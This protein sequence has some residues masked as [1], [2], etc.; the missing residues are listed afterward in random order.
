[1]KS[2]NCKKYCNGLLCKYCTPFIKKENPINGIRCNFIGDN[3][4]ILVMQRPPLYY[5][6]II[7]EQFKKNNIKSI[8][9]LQEIG[10]HPD[11][12]IGP[13]LESGFTYDPQ[14]FIKEDINYYHYPWT[15]MTSPALELIEDC[16]LKMIK[17]VETS[18]KI[19]IHCHSG[20]NRCSI[21][22]ACFLIHFDKISSEKAIDIVRRDRKGTLTFD[23]QIQ[24]VKEYEQYLNTKY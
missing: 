18:F 1:M 8:Y 4:L 20:L 5:T 9:N 14:D 2:F 10:E 22:V 13:L 6:P 21:L 17:D 24:T 12:G 23:S 16:V 15:D 11:C 3:K 7:I 19:A